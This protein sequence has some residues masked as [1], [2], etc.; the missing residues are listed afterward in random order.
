[1]TQT[2]WRLLHSK[3]SKQPTREGNKCSKGEEDKTNNIQVVI[4]NWKEFCNTEVFISY[5]EIFFEVVD[6][7]RDVFATLF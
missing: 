3:S 5:P 2:V 4:N 7:D 6:R 1:M